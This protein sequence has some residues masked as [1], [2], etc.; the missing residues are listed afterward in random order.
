MW[1]RTGNSLLSTKTAA[2]SSPYDPGVTDCPTVLDGVLDEPFTTA[3]GTNQYR[4]D[5]G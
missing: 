3:D 4:F 1:S 5:I 2:S